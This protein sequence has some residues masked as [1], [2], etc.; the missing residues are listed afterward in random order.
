VARA[1]GSR[2]IWVSIGCTVG[3]SAHYRF[4][5]EDG[6]VRICLG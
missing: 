4:V 5:M 1:L 3:D 2:S 6:Q